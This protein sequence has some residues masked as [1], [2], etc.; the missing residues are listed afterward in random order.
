MKRKTKTMITLRKGVAYQMKRNHV[1]VV[2]GM[3]TFIDDHTVDVDG[4]RYSGKNVMI[5]TG[6]SPIR[7]PIPGVD[8]PHVLT[9]SEIFDI[10]QL[11]EKLVIVG[12]GVIGMEF[13]CFFSAVGVEVTVVQDPE[14][15]EMMRRFIAERPELWNEDIGV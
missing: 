12:G 15:I 3:A 10:E 5:A 2:E 8:L 7:P 11:P 9:S 1:D 14:C 6:S 13:A 4:Q